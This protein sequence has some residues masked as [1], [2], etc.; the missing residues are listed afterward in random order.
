MFASTNNLTQLIDTHTQINE[1][2]STAIDLLFVNNKH[3]IVSSGVLPAH[4]SDHSLIYCVVKSGVTKCP[5]RT[6]QYTSY[7][8]YSKEAFLTDLRNVDWNIIDEVPDINNAVNY[9]NKMFTDVAECH[10]PTKRTRIKGCHVPWMT[11]YKYRKYRNVTVVFGKLP[12]LILHLTGPNIK[13]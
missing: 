2:S 4:I 12:N 10:A 1:V 5:G 8:H 9:W 6:I 7:K 11:I 13:A 3:R